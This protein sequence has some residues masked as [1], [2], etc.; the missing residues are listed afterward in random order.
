MGTGIVSVGLASDSERLLSVVLL[1]IAAAVWVALGLSVAWRARHDRARVRRE[2]GSPA[3]LTAVAGTAVLGA[4][5]APLGWSGVAAALLAIASLIWVLLVWPVRRS[6]P[7]KAAGVAFMLAVST[8]SL[9]V[10]AAQLAVRERG[11]WLLYASLALFALGLAAYAFVLLRFDLGHLLAGRGDQWVAGGGLAI[12]AVA[13]ARITI[14]ARHLHLLESSAG[15]LR[16][17]SLVLWAL[18]LAWLPVLLAAEVIRP[19]LRY[20][21][22][23]WA[24]VFPV[25]M[26]A[27]ASFDVGQAARVQGPVQFARVWVWIGFALW[28]VVLAAAIRRVSTTWNET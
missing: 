8:Q 18:S 25:G 10:L 5:V 12:S 7:R 9:T 19:R 17:M 20:D 14:G 26:V 6:W 15:A 3:A 11:P 16:T 13:A 22:R 21:I 4:R 24:T 2:A 23:R 1:V 27:A 28:C